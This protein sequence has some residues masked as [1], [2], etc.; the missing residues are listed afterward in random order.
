M[1]VSRKKLKALV[2][3]N[4]AARK[5][6]ARLR[7]EIQRLSDSNLDLWWDNKMLNFRVTH[8]PQR[9]AGHYFYTKQKETKI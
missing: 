3:E 5:E 7:K 8:K 1:F 6:N 4:V 2:D 9:E